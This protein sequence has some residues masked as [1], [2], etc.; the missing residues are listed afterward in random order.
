MGVAYDESIS[1]ALFVEASQAHQNGESDDK[2]MEFLGGSSGFLSF[3]SDEEELSLALMNLDTSE[4][5]PCAP[6]SALLSWV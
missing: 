1:R 3:R 6:S 5:G 2:G 4:R